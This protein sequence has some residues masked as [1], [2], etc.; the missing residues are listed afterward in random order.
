MKLKIFALLILVA[1]LFTFCGS[2]PARAEFASPESAENERLSGDTQSKIQDLFNKIETVGSNYN[3]GGGSAAA[4]AAID[5]GCRAAIDRMLQTR[6]FNEVKKGLLPKDTLLP[7]IAKEYLGNKS[8]ELGQTAINNICAALKGDDITKTHSFGKDLRRDLIPRLMSYGQELSKSTGLPFLSRIE[9]EGGVSDR[10][11]FSSITSVQPI[12]ADKDGK[13]HAFAQLSYYN[14]QSEKTDLGFKKQYSTFNA[15]LAYRHLTLDKKYLYGANIFLDHAP[16]LNHNRM[17]FGVDAR[18]S[19]LAVSANRY[20]PI[21]GWRKINLYYEE[22]AAAGWDVLVRGQVPQLPSWTASV[23]GFEW[24]EQDDGQ[25]LYGVVGSLQ[26]SPVPA[27]AVSVG[28][29]DDSQSKPSLEAAMRFNL[30]FDQPQ[31]LQWRE[32]TALAPVSDFIY[33]KVQR[34][35][36]IRVKQRRGAFSKLTVIQSIGANTAAEALGTSS[37]FVGQSLLMPVTVTVANTIGAIGRLQFSDGSILTLGQNTQVT[38]RPDLITLIFGTMQYVSNGTI[39]NVAVPGGTI[40]LHGTDID[41]VSNGVNS[42]VRVRDGSVDFIGTASGSATLAPEQA[43]ESIAG[44]IG[45]LA[46]GSAGYITH[47]DTISTKID[48]IAAVQEGAKVTPYPYEIPRVISSNM[49]IGG[50]IELALRFNDAVTVTGGPPRIAF[51]INGFSRFAN[52]ASGS[53]TDDLH[54]TYTN[55]AA[56]VSATS[57]TVNG[58]DKNTGAIMGNGKDAVTTIA[59]VSLSLTGGTVDVTPPSGYAAVFTTAPVNSTNNTAAAFNITGAEL[60]TTYSYSITSSGGGTALTG[61][62]TISSATQSFTG[63]NVSGLGDGTLTVSVTLTDAG[64]NAGAVTPGTAI[65]DI[66][67]PFITSVTAPA[68]ATYEP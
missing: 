54:F 51:T 2:F 10:S 6:L 57:L 5:V 1:T 30:R 17:S 48:R 21:S 18:T 61:T 9:I 15:G 53:G 49:I 62:G 59:D 8:Q 58:L 67:A 66:V 55:V 28:V 37:L 41:V 32:A 38:I 43:A 26:Y 63:L 4:Y 22:R 11:L 39:Q 60:G 27:L 14:T 16:Q 13:H 31:D 50:V 64:G 44:V 12:W 35:N 33:E 65:K 68:N 46:I 23:K 19:Q 7:N 45:N 20:F 34:D 25:N 42:S 40:I 3:N 36:I 29:R 52:Y 56:D 24:D 47:T